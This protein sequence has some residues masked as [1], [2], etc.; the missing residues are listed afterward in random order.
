MHFN[1]V[2]MI[3][4]CYIKV[5]KVKIPGIFYI[6]TMNDSTFALNFTRNYPQVH[7]DSLTAVNTFQTVK[8][9]ID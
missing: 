9:C 8:M 1:V 7:E 3:A 5:A 4:Q 6:N 2:N